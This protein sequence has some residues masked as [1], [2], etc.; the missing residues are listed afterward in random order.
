MSN[1]SL[2]ALQEMWHL[3][4]PDALALWSKFTRL[5]EPVWCMDDAQAAREGLTQSFAMIR[6][7]D[8]TIVINLKLIQETHLEKFALEILGHEIGHHVYCPADLTDH[9]RMIAR[10]R[11]ALPTVEQHASF[12]GNLYTDLL[13]NNRLQRD[14]S[15]RIADVYRAIERNKNKAAP[16]RMWTF[17]LRIYEILWSIEKG[18]LARGKMDQDLEGDAYL[19]ARLIRSYAREWLEGSGHF[20][21]L[22]LPYLLD[23]QKQA[24]Q[25]ML[26]VWRDTQ[27]A[28]AHG[29]PDGLTEMDSDEQSGALHPAL[30]PELSGVDAAPKH[31]DGVKTAPLESNGPLVTNRQYREPFEYGQILKNLGMDLDDHEIAVRYYKERAAPHLVKFPVR[32]IPQATDPL[33]EGLEPWDIGA[34]LENFDAVAS[35]QYSPHVIPGLT[36]LERVYGTSEG[37]SPEKRPVDL[38]LYVDCSGSMPNPQMR[39]SYPTLAGAI[40]A[41]SAL[42]VGACVQATLWSG[43]GQFETTGDFLRNE[44]RVLQILT[45]YLGGATA[46]PLHMFRKTYE[47]R[48]ANARPVHILII[49][50]NGATTIYQPDE[51]NVEGGAI[52]RMALASAKG[53]GT[54]ALNLYPTWRQHEPLLLQAEREGWAIF[55]VS[56]MEQLVDFAKAFSR[57]KYGEN[58]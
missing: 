48:K 42:R 30:D 26:Q 43:A 54:M 6:L 18:K 58:G 44:H 31:K 37:S 56:T 19:G 29:M 45:G 4:F 41:L 34:P 23:D 39:L 7:D 57:I 52:A 33:P 49:S 28:G 55:P 16:P 14:S 40:I 25:Q 11:W 3:R 1:Q 27:N 51:K 46:F 5:R 13:I 38:D 36:T 32:E 15:L 35:V 12:V 20:A 9:A 50:D 17:Y 10:M 22:C 24:M 8:Q 21:A 2:L 53:G 47:Q